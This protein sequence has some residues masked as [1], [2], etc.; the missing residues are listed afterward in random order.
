MHVAVS[1]S[2]VFQLRGNVST[3]LGKLGEVTMSQVRALASGCRGAAT[4]TWS[5]K[6]TFLGEWLTRYIEY[7][8]VN[9]IKT[10]HKRVPPLKHLLGLI[11]AKEPSALTTEWLNE[12]CKDLIRD[13]GLKRQGGLKPRSIQTYRKYV[14][15]LVNFIVAKRGL[16]RSPFLDEKLPAI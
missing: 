11:L 3:T 6:P 14:L 7:P 2:K 1:G 12:R 8:R 16:D 13:G 15:M 10:M 5:R 4:E 9:E